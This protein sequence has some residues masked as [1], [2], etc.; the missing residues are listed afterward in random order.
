MFEY[1]GKYFMIDGASM[2][3]PELAGGRAP[4]ADRKEKEEEEEQ[5]PGTK[6]RRRGKTSTTGPAMG[7]ASR[8]GRWHLKPITAEN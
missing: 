8:S 6:G 4:R 2:T 7:K 3:P 1:S 5:G